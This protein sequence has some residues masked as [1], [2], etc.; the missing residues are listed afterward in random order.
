M[1]TDGGLFLYSNSPLTG[2]GRAHVVMVFD[3][4][5]TKRSQY[6]Y[7]NGKLDSTITDI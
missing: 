6:I 7:L 4:S 2:I 5:S 1:W 3:G